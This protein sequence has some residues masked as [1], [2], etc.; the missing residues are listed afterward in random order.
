MGDADALFEVV[1]FVSELDESPD[2]VDSFELVVELV[3]LV[4]LLESEVLE[5]EELLLVLEAVSLDELLLSELVV[6]SAEEVVEEAV[7]EAVEEKEVDVGP[8]LVL[9]G[10]ELKLL[11]LVTPPSNELTELE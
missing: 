1:G 7:E 6:P 2:D 10:L 8:L 5:P 3:E 11:E 9:V 4:E